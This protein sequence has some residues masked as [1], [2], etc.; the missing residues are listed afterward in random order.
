METI[1]KRIHQRMYVLFFFSVLLNLIFGYTYL[2]NEPDKKSSQY[3]KQIEDSKAILVATKRIYESKLAAYKHRMDSLS[4]LVT[5]QKDA[6]STSKSKT[7]GIKTRM[8]EID[9]GLSAQ[10]FLDRAAKLQISQTLSDAG[11][12]LDTKDSLLTAQQQVYEQ[13]LSEKDSMIQDCD[14]AYH[15]L[16]EQLQKQIEVNQQLTKDLRKKEKKEKRRRFFNK[17]LITG[18]SIVA[19]VLILT[20]P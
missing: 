14:T 6:I 4:G 20:Q 8:K 11:S 9:K 7:S 1:E 2:K 19:A 13:V 5:D 15:V 10:D 16:D 18:G 17:V 3:E 12:E